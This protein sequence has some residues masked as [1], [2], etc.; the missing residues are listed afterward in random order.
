MSC[1]R[2][3]YDKDLKIFQLLA[4]P[5]LQSQESDW[6]EICS[7]RSYEL[8]VSGQLPEWLQNVAC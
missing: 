8:G 6:T 1:T 2:H 5:G 4:G 7:M 3:T